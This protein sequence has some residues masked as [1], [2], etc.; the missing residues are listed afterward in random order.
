MGNAQIV[1]DTDILI[2]YLRQHNQLLREA[3]QHFDCALTAIA[4]YELKAIPFI[5]ERQRSLLSQL[6]PIVETLAFDGAAADYASQ[7]WRT[8]SER[9]TPIG[10]PDIL[11]AGVCLANDLPIL[12]RNF[13]HFSRVDGLKVIAPD[14]L[15][16][17]IHS[18]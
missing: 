17:Y 15:T 2:D 18:R 8:L 6:L 10:L 14:E 4:L 9:G 16:S 11:S 3:L 7:I 13:E 12:T 1:V 5:S